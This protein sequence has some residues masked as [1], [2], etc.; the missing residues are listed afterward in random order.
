MNQYKVDLMSSF[1]A[2]T[3]ML[4]EDFDV[5]MGLLCLDIQKKV[6]ILRLHEKNEFLSLSCW[7]TVHAMQ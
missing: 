3:I 7:Q 6:D 2:D 1:K 4:T 5:G